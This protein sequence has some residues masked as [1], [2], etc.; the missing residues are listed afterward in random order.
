VVRVHQ[1][2]RGQAAAALGGLFMAIWLLAG[3]MLASAFAVGL[4]MV[5]VIVAQG[6]NG[7]PPDPT[8][9]TLGGFASLVAACGLLSLSLFVSYSRARRF[10]E[11]S[12][13][14]G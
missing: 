6:P 7:G 3:I 4:V 13:G 9:P 14:R 1:T 8:H 10:L 2:P 5:V 11:G 12:R